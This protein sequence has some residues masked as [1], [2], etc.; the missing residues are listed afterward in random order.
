M[1]EEGFSEEQA[2]EIAENQLAPPTDPTRAAIRGGFKFAGILA[3]YAA[4][5]QLAVRGAR[6]AAPMWVAKHAKLTSAMTNI[7]AFNAVG[8]I[9]ESF[10]PED[11]RNRAVRAAID[12]GLGIAFPVA[13]LAYRRLVP[14][15][16]KLPVSVSPSAVERLVP[17]GEKVTEESMVAGAK[18]ILKELTS[19]KT[20]TPEEKALRKRLVTGLKNDT[21]DLARI[22]NEG[23]PRGV[24][25]KKGDK[26]IT[27]E[28]SATSSGKNTGK[29][30]TIATNNLEA[31]QNTVK[32][33]AEIDYKA[34]TNLG[35][36]AAGNK[37]VARHEFNPKTGKH[38]IFATNKATVEDLSHEL[39]HFFDKKLS[40]SIDGL[41]RA[42]A[43]KDRGLLEDMLS[44]FAVARLGAEATSK[45]ISKEIEA[46]V[47]RLGK[48][49]KTLA[50]E[51][52]GTVNKKPS[53]AFADAVSQLVVGKSAASKQAPT[54][55]ALIEHTSAF[56][57]AAAF[58]ETVA[59]Q[60]TKKGK[61]AKGVVEKEA[62]TTKKT[63]S[64]KESVEE[65]VEGEVKKQKDDVAT[66]A[67]DL[68][69]GKITAEEATVKL[70]ETA[71]KGKKVREVQKKLK[72][73]ETGRQPDT[74]AIRADKISAAD[75]IV[76][77]IEEKVI[78]QVTGKHRISRTNQEILDSSITS[79]MTEK[80]FLKI[81][82]VRFGN[83]SGDVVKAK[84]FMNDRVQTIRDRL[85]G[86]DVD[87]LSG[88]EL[89]ELMTEYNQLTELFEVF[90]GV[91]TELSNSFRSLG[92][93]VV[94]GEN[95]VLRRT[96]K[97]VQKILG[98]EGD[99]FG[100]TKKAAKLRE[101]DWVDT[102]FNLWYPLIL[103]GPKTTVR[104]LVGT[105]ANLIT[106]TMS[107]LLAP[108]G[109]KEFP[110][111]ILAM[112][113]A[114]G[115]AW[116]LA[117]QVQR[118]DKEIQSKFH[119]TKGLQGADFDK[120]FGGKIGFLNKLE[121]VGRFLNAQDIFFSTIAGEGEVAAMRAGKLTFGG[122]SKNV[123]KELYDGVSVLYGK[124]VSYRNPYEGASLSK[125]GAAITSLKS[126][127]NQYLKGVATFIF[128]F[129]RTVV[130]VTE[131]KID[132]LPILNIPRTFFNG[133]FIGQ[134]RRIVRDSSLKS[135]MM[136]NLT[137]KGTSVAEAEKMVAQE[138]ER[139]SEIIAQRMKHQQLGKF[140]MGTAVAAS[141]V[142]LAMMGN[143]TGSGPKDKR[144]RDALMLTGW[145]PNSIR[146]AGGKVHLPYMF[147]G[148]LAG[149][150]SI[151]GNISD[152]IKYNNDDDATTSEKFGEML[153]AM[154]QTE[155]DQS[156]L[157]GISNIV[158][159]IYGYKPL[160]ESMA[161]FA[162]NALVPIP[163]A[164]TQTK[165]IIMPNRFE[166]N[167]LLQQIQ[168]KVGVT[169]GLEP[170]LD[171]FG[172]QVGADLIWGLTP[173]MVVTNDPVFNFMQDS[174]VFI[175]KP[176]RSQKIKN[177][178]TGEER[179]MTPEEYTVF[180]QTQGEEIYER[181]E[182]AIKAGRFDRLSEEQK[183]KAVS[184]ITREA[185]ARAKSI[186][187]F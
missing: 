98:K 37:I 104:N 136:G 14:T 169:Y 127:E 34:V 74:P 132:Y 96:V 110:E 150:L 87:S 100:F 60:V 38:T 181:M 3:P 158:D 139:V 40:Q 4:A 50:K 5:E 187:K 18:R 121:F 93:E 146:L 95:E 177:R 163:A 180:V 20:L 36:D 97:E 69:S 138:I 35:K 55:A 24:G 12:T 25:L 178:R 79:D 119:E 31:L 171:T 7:G 186:I 134:A 11:E 140:Y 108:G 19:K 10:L 88:P 124:K 183:E 94:P 107:T 2:I 47:T 65:I 75:E 84:R 159:T 41:S 1:E 27:I 15:K 135:E 71:I 176:N 56:D 111:R 42:M 54:L 126:S 185:R 143:I 131:R 45:Q 145:R 86:K 166:S 81:L 170:K 23:L 156:F 72:R 73:D 83:L 167:N 103:S 57:G 63:K 85:L 174:N 120:Y 62:E 89:K 105:G 48:E 46:V 13:G 9:E 148:P 30:L 78:P 77:V 59:K 92:L 114:Q 32:G 113:N 115:K 109:L 164:W 66:I 125:V 128:P 99:D 173:K 117:R 118:G 43:G 151:A 133:N 80:D 165:D 52:K 129:V 101:N 141:T 26:T 67:K 49:V 157:S 160:S 17:A 122:V 64:K 182:R 123:E 28:T 116:E 147:L 168:N 22:Q 51:R 137:K 184:K 91:R 144:Q 76:K 44:T 61:V 154:M 68:E 29:K 6:Y 112:R 58:S 102:Y 155:L 130:N 16:F 53:E 161:H 90:T 152:G 106:E 149:V 82:Q 172:K 142:P 33:S 21:V 162:A 179:K 175:G 8:Q 70:K 39:G 153:R